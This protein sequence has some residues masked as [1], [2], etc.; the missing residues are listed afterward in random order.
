MSYWNCVEAPFMWRHAALGDI[1]SFLE[2]EA[3]SGKFH[4]QFTEASTSK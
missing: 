1:K 4:P 2:Y 3:K